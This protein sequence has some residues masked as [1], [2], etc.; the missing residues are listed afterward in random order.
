[1][2][3]E[4]PIITWLKWSESASI[5]VYIKPNCENEVKLFVRELSANKNKSAG[6]NDILPKVVKAVINS[7]ALQLVQIF[8]KSSLCGIFPNELK[9]ANVYPVCKP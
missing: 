5:Y 8:N 7:I 2:M 9:V 3:R 1:M 4:T 6:Q